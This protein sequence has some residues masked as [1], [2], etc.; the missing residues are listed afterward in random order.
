KGTIRLNN[1]PDWIEGE[2]QVMGI[3]AYKSNNLYIA[4]ANYQGGA[5]VKVN[6]ESY[7]TS[8]SEVLLRDLGYVNSIHLDEAN[9]RL[10][11]SVSDNGEIYDLDLVNGDVDIIEG[12][13]FPNGMAQGKD[14]DWLYVSQT[15]E[16][17]IIRI[18]LKDT[19]IREIVWVGGDSFNSWPD[20]LT[21]S[22]EHDMFLVAD[23]RSGAIISITPSGE[24][25]KHVK[26]IGREGKTAPASLI[27]HEDNVLFTD[28]WVADMPLVLIKDFIDAIKYKKNAYK[29]PL[30]N[31]LLPSKSEFS[32]QKNYT[33]EYIVPI[34][35]VFSN[36]YL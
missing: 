29:V 23:N 24:L 26:M 19:S 7:E 8:M 30:T 9:D 28:L 13:I 12:L 32:K 15:M 17:N 10:F 31:F 36:S 11:I 21:Y 1:L 4:L 5:L 22:K 25:I 2:S 20:G 27:I 18:N 6:T 3:L 35:K 16:S 33:Y 14:A 34:E